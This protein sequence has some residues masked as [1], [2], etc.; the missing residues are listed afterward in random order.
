MHKSNFFDGAAALIKTPLMD[1]FMTPALGGNLSSTPQ[2]RLIDFAK[3]NN[4]RKELKE[5]IKIPLLAMA[6]SSVMGVTAYAATIAVPGPVDQ[7]QVGR[8]VTTTI[9]AVPDQ[10][11]PLLTVATFKFTPDVETIGQALNQVLQ[12]SGYALVPPQDQTPLVQQT[13]TK[14]LPY[15]VRALGPIEI[16]D[17]LTV[18]M[19]QNV[20]ILVV[21]PL[22]RLVNFD[23]KPTILNALYPQKAAA[24]VSSSNLSNS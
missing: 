21:D 13:L 16:K 9:G 6:M 7:S 19:G 22:H 24:E 14:P 1:E 17:A 20:F 8:Y 3:M 18:L 23:V 2:R 15:S 4:R 11:D 10:V 5:M 12:Y